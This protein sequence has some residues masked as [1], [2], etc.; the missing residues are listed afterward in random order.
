MLICCNPV[1]KAY[2]MNVLKHPLSKDFD[3]DYP[4]VQYVDDTL[5][6]MPIDA[7]QL[8]TLKGLLK[9]FTDST[10]LRVNFSKSFLVPI[11]MDDEKATHLAN[12]IGFSIGSTP[13][14]YL[15]LPL[16]TTRPSVDEFSPFLNKIEK[17]MMDINK[18]LSYPGRLLLVNSVLSALPTFYMLA[19]KTPIKILDQVDKYR[20]IAYGTEVIPKEM[21][22]V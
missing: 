1:N 2:E 20:K 17:R 4:I 19:L 22:D 8:V 10:G 21:V 9:S 16:G 14:T 7:R 12:T 3:L 13:F 6:T 11:N 15:C 18:L 5:I